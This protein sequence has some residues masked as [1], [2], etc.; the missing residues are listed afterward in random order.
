MR[1][2][3]IGSHRTG[4]LAAA[5]T[6]AFGLYAGTNAAPPPTLLAAN[7]P[8]AAPQPE[9]G[10]KYLGDDNCSLCHEKENSRFKTDLVRLNEYAIWE[11]ADPHHV[12]AFKALESAT[13]QS[14]GQRLGWPAGGAKDPAHGCIACH[15]VDCR[16]TPC[17][18][19]FQVSQGVSCEACHG[20]ASEWID[21]HWHEAWRNVKPEE[22]ERKYG[23]VNVRDPRA[24]PSCAPRAT[25]VRR[26][27][28]NS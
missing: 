4:V 22:K 16:E 21:R 3:A 14:I 17:D 9:A 26:T 10:R 15:A 5:A 13:A 12:K 27:R 23:M 25:W 20:P 19:R 2:K 24:R 6:L 18:A 11:K 1:N 8:F 7:D 28:E